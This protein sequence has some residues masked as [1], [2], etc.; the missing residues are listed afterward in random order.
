MTIRQNDVRTEFEKLAEFS[1]AFDYGHDNEREIAIVGCAYIESLLGEILAATFLDDASEVKLLTGDTGPLG[2]LVARARLLYLLG[3]VPE[4]VY[5]DIK[6]IGKIRNEFAHKVS[7]SF[8][9]DRVRDL[10][11]SL[12][13]HELSMFMKPPADASTRDIYQVGVNQ[14]V[15]HLGGLPGLQRLE[16][17]RRS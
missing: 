13:W 15:C 17:A 11:K 3:V 9:D 14:V 4:L 16:R 12:K 7:A 6:I 2:S 10:C 5:K 1:L 8:S